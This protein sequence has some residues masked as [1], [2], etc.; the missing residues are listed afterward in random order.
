MIRKCMGE[1]GAHGLVWVSMNTMLNYEGEHHVS[2][3]SSTHTFICS[4]MHVMLQSDRSI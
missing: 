4:S 3:Q 1:Y 2:S